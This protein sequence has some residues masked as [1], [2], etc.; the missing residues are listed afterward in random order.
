MLCQAI[1]P[2]GRRLD[3]FDTVLPDL[4]AD[5]GFVPVARLKWNDDYAPAGGA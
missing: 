3:C 5:A 2:G 4:Y 1:V